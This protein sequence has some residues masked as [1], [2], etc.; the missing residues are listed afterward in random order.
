MKRSP[1]LSSALVLAVTVAPWA[2]ARAPQL[3]SSSGVNSAVSAFAQLSYIGNWSNGRGE[4][5]SITATRIRFANDKRLKYRDVTKV[6]DGQHFSLQITDRGKLNYF[7]KFLSLSLGE[8]DKPGEMK[9]TLYNSY[10]DMFDGKN[11]QG[12]A[13]WY[14]D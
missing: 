11:P 5:I 6:T 3:N 14:R 8:G 12:E 13:T 4:T 7:T 2:M 10:E 9:I 1:L